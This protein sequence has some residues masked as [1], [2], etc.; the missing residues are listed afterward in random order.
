MI[1]LKLLEEGEVNLLWETNFAGVEGDL[2]LPI[3]AGILY[4]MIPNWKRVVEFYES[5]TF[6]NYTTL[7]KE[8]ENVVG[9][10]LS[11]FRIKCR[12]REEKIGTE[13]P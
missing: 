12:V 7:S 4:R 10:E 3:G 6:S 13:F 1:D 2:R 11:F 9:M 5:R 8:R